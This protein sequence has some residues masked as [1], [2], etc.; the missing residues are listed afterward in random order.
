MVIFVTIAAG[1][2]GALVGAALAHRW[3]KVPA[4]AVAPTTI[5]ETVHQ[6]PPLR[7]LMRSR[8]D[9]STLTDLR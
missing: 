3:P 6:H 1:A 8:L 9:A 7:R 2:I 4:P 5:T